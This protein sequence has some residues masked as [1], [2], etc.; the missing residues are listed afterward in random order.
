M[1]FRVAATLLFLGVMAA[2]AFPGTP[3]LAPGEALRSL[4]KRYDWQDMAVT[5]RR[6]PALVG[7]ALRF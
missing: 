2:P 3:S 5:P 1:S 4:V 6:Q 7:V